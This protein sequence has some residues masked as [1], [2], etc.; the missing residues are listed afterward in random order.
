MTAEFNYQEAF[1]RNIGWISEREQEQLRCKKIAI[2]GMGGVG[3][4]HLMTLTRLGVG[5]F[6]I[7]DLDR[8]ELANMN[9]QAGA[10]MATLCREK[11]DV[12]AAMVRDINPEV[13]LKIFEEGVDEGNI[14]AFLAEV[15]L[16]VDGFDFFVIDI[17]RK[18]FA[19]CAE[20]GIPA[21]TAAPIGFGAAYIIFMPGRM[22]FEQYFRLDG[23]AEE[24]QYVNFALGLTPKGFHRSYLVDPSRLDFAGKRSPSTS[25]AIQL[26]S[27]VVGAEAMKILVGRGTV[28]AA[29]WYNQFDAFRARWKR[30]LLPLGN[31]G[32]LQALK[33]LIGY[34]AF[35]RLSRNARPYD[36]PV[37]GTDIEKILDFARWAPSGDNSQPWR[38]EKSGEDRLILHFDVEGQDENIYDYHNGQPTLLSGGFF[39]ET[40]RVAAS[41]FGRG[42]QWEYLGCEGGDHRLSVELT[43]DSSVVEDDLSTWIAIRS[44]DR[45]PYLTIPLTDAQKA[46]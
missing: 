30:G 19:R 12:M 39:L 15:D 24:R 14:D 23:H 10:S 35:A 40:L 27:G 32:P 1:S 33:R 42:M 25:A 11:T 6:H 16:F 29:P 21:I 37:Q 5:S 8:F 26:C 28:Y 44:V 17:R 31:N 45:R 4:A 34:K 9:R 41:R 43:Q 13:D 22:T 36:A 7:A 3:G 20:L 2:A 46:E 38:Y 18:V